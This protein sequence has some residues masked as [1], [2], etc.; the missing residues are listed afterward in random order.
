MLQLLYT[1]QDKNE[2]DDTVIKAY[3]NILFG[4]DAGKTIWTLFIESNEFA[5]LL[6][7]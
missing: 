4:T 1:G 5:H 6:N 7:E 2:N 3:Q